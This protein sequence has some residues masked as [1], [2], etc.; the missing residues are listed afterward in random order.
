MNCTLTAQCSHSNAGVALDCTGG[1][2]QC[3]CSMNG[4]TGM[5]VNYDST[6]CGS[7]TSAALNAA[8]SACGWNL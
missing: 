8:N 3:V 6:F 4:V 5:T 2:N 7:D 1:M